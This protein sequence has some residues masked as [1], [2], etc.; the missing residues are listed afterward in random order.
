M[1]LFWRRKQI[2]EKEKEHDRQSSIE[3]VALKKKTYRTAEQTNRDIDKLNR[4]L[5]ADGI[6]LKIHIA[7]GGHGGA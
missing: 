2:I 6:T 7:S 4:L 1:A 5:R 3:V